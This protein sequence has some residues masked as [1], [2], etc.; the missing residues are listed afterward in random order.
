MAGY[1]RR[2]AH[3]ATVRPAYGFVGLDGI[4]QRREFSLLGRGFGATLQRIRS[5]DKQRVQVGDGRRGLH[6]RAALTEGVQI[7]VR[8]VDLFFHAPHLR[9]NRC[10][11]C[12]WDMVSEGP[13]RSATRPPQGERRWVVT[14]VAAGVN[15]VA[16]ARESSR[17]RVW[18]WCNSSFQSRSPA[19]SPV[20]RRTSFPSR[21]PSP[22]L[23]R[24]T[25]QR[26][27]Q[28]PRPS[29][30]RSPFQSPHLLTKRRESS[31]SPRL[32]RTTNRRSLWIARG[33]CTAGTTAC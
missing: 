21:C 33:C 20:V 11:F 4:S 23:G 26:T 14:W 1:G 19:P 9:S 18:A 17:K 16:T 28:S 10:A 6:G 8:G 2:T 29:T 27:S 3:G 5:R 22:R 15:L 31:Q 24:S 25:S 7:L 13:D 32:S 12:G 30:R